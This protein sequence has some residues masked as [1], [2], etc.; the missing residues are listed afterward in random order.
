MNSD[1]GYTIKKYK[2]FSYIRLKY[3]YDKDNRRHVY[4]LDP[5][6]YGNLYND[7][8]PTS[9]LNINLY[10]AKVRFDD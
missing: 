8:N 1:D 9:I 7:Q 2:K 10:E 4:F 3:C 5:E 6:Y